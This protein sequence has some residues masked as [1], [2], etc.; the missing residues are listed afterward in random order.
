M[1]REDIIGEI[2]A[3]IENEFN[4]RAALPAGYVVAIA[5]RQNGRQIGPS[6]VVGSGLTVTTTGFLLTITAAQ[7]SRLSTDIPAQLRAKVTTADGRPLGQK[8]VD[9]TVI[10]NLVS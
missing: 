7:S 1:E 9:V 10:A 4:M 8:E 5:L 6:L 2:T 3:G